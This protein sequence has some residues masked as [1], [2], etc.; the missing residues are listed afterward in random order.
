M[1]VRLATL[2]WLGGIM[3]AFAGCA[4]QLGN[5]TVQVGVKVNEQAVNDSLEHVAQRLQAEMTRM[6]LQVA[7]APDGDVVRLTSTTKSGQKFVVVLSRLRGSQG[8]QTNVHIDW[9]KGCDKDLWMQLILVAG[10][11]ALT[12]RQ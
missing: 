6:G 5:S 8:E 1:M 4:F 9:D 12:P 2:F 10:Q 11:T 3:A 7:V